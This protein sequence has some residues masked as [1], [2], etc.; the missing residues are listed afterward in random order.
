MK[1]LHLADAHIGMENYGRINPSTGLH[2]RLEDFA[3]S[4]EF[5]V[6]VAISEK[7]DAVLFAGDAY[8]TCDPS[9][10]HQRA[11]SAQMVK[12]SRAGIPLVMILGNHDQPVSA[13]KAS[14]L[15]IFS[16]LSVPHTFLAS[17]PSLIPVETAHGVLQVAAFPWPIRSHFLSREE[18]RKFSDEELQAKIEE[19]CAKTITAL[20]EKVY[21][22]SPAVLL[23]HLTCGEATYSGSERTATIGRDPVFPVSL[24]ASRAF[25]HVALGHIHKAQDLHPDGQP[26]VVY[27]GSLDRV[28]FGE[29]ED[30]K[31]ISLV[32]IEGGKGRFEWIQVPAREFLT[33]EVEI[34]GEHDDPTA[35][36]IKKVQEHHLAQKVVRLYYYFS[37]AGQPHASPPS[38]PVTGL[39]LSAVSP[40]GNGGS[41]PPIRMQEV[42]ASLSQAFFVAGVYERRP[43]TGKKRTRA[44][45]K[46]GTGT[47]DLLEL[48]ISRNPSLEPMREK[49]RAH[50]AI[51]EEKH[52]SA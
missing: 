33:M 14:A 13:G 28:N 27:P 43:E 24:L 17:S 42:Q 32:T 51:L 1:I 15:E 48:Y 12:L 52:G 6:E 36:L 41:H 20:A 23:A 16:T 8:R 29:E 2:T 37:G 39:D 31:R 10:T 4:L 40:G 11:F 26:H 49:I 9:P 38:R 7:V 25:Q 21:S 44:A 18:Y 5:A 34:P 22:A 30:E 35:F 3:R 46:E 19:E 47:L 45:I 50:A